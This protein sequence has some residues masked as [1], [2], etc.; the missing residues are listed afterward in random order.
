[1]K[2]EGISAVVSGGASGLGAAVARRVAAA[3]GRVTLID[4]NAELGEALA[5]ELGDGAAFESGD[6]SDEARIDDVFANAVRRNGNVD[7][8]VSCAGIIGNGLVL[9]RDGVMPLDYYAKVIQVNL[10]G[11]FNMAR[12]G[13]AAMR[14]NDPN[15]DGERG[16]IVNTASVAGYEGQIGQAAYASSKGGVIGLT[17]PLAREFARYGIRVMAIAPGLFVT[18]MVA[19]LPESAQASLAESIPF[20][21]RLGEPAEYADLVATIVVNPMLN[22]EVIRL[23]GAVRLQ[24]K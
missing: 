23:D 3:G 7:L 2:F 18:P 5:Q 13:A 4:L 22:G 17:L 21:K 10:I 12:A 16:V 8:V 24:P 6:V 11:T 19:G 20:P 15:A 1:M 14:D 9:P